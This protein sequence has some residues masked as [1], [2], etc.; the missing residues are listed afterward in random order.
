MWRG[1]LSIIAV[2]LMAGAAV[3]IIPILVIPNTEL[4]SLVPVLQPLHQAL[5]CEAG[6]TLDY[7]Y[8]T[9]ADGASETHF[10]CVNA[11]GRERDVDSVLQTPANY[12]I[13]VFCL[14]GLL[15]LGP[16]LI[17]VR[18]G[19]LGQAGPA[20]QAALQQGVSAAASTADRDG[21]KLPRRPSPYPVNSSSPRWTNCASRGLITPDAYARAKQKLF[22]DFSAT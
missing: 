8:T 12:A 13:G 10:R 18:Q 2:L 14:G 22:D 17:A 1:I 4:H 7:E 16:F 20:A 5:A 11:A 9:D 19:M 21:A 6:E 3:I 15:L